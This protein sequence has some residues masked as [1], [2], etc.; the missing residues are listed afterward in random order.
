MERRKFITLTGV[1]VGLCIIPASLYVIGSDLKTYAA[2]IL[3]KEL[4]Y[5]KLEPKGFSVYIEDYFKFIKN[6]TVATLKWKILY[7]TNANW[8][9][10]DSIRDLIKYYLLSSDFFINKTDE[11]K[12]VNYLGLFNSYKSPIPNPYSFVLYP[13]DEIKDV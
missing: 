6:D 8:E 3:K 4:F 1:G 2:L 5:L 13:P 11:S 12:T 9:K 10:S 7:Y